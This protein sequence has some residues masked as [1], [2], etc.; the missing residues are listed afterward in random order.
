VALSM[1]LRDVERVGEDVLLTLRPR[2]P[3]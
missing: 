1:E 3:G 2:P